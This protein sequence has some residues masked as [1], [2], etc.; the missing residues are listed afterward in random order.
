ML[1][2]FVG[3]NTLRGVDLVQD[4]AATAMPGGDAK[5]SSTRSLKDCP[6]LLVTCAFSGLQ[7]C[8][9]GLVPSP[10]ATTS[11]RVNSRSPCD[12]PAAHYD[13]SV[14]RTEVSWD[15]DGS[16]DATERHGRKSLGDIFRRDSSGNGAGRVEKPR[17]CKLYESREVPS[18]LT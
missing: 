13:N 4:D 15:D 6:V 11:S 18:D 17:L 10:A 3:Q 7:T 2:C 9:G 8:C 12:G 1:S 5:R 14:V 16:D